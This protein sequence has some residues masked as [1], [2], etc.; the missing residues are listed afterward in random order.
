VLTAQR[1]CR[2]EAADTHVQNIVVGLLQPAQSAAGLG[3]GLYAWRPLALGGGV[4]ETGSNTAQ[5]APSIFCT[6]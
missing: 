2:Q 1:A 5:R 3:A 4:Q 6:M